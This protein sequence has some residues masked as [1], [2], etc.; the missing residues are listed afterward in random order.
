MTKTESFRLFEDQ[1]NKIEE[2]VKRLPDKY[3]SKSHFVRAAI[4]KLLNE[5]EAQRIFNKIA[6]GG[7][8]AN[9]CKM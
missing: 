8:N 5:E 4:M 3:E 1:P 6:R 7:N 9:R 2:I